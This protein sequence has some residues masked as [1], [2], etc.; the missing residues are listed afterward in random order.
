[1]AR[2]DKAVALWS[3]FRSVWNRIR[4]RDVQ[5]RPDDVFLVSYPRSG[6]TWLRFLLGN[7]LTYGTQTKIDF[8]SVRW[9]I[10]DVHVPEQRATLSALPSPRLIKS[11]SQLNPEYPRVVYLV[12]DGRDVY[13]SYYHYL[14]EQGQFEGSFTEFL[15]RE[16]LPYGLWHEHVESWLATQRDASL[17]LVRY[18]D[19]LAHP[20]DELERI[21]AFIDLDPSPA[22][23]NH[24]VEN[25]S[26]TRMRKIERTAGRP[27]G[28]PEYR[29]VRHGTTGRWIDLFGSEDR[30]IMRSRAN[31]ILSQLGYIEVTEW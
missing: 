21:A 14:S 4:G 13:A 29:F 16:N 5:I 30:R 2:F 7:L 22:Q 31:R 25:S 6:S 1:M 18:E 27:Y 20:H 26:L 23:V 15:R 11:H 28:D 17:L 3:K 9:M 24:A 19:L 10:P 12:R 8:F